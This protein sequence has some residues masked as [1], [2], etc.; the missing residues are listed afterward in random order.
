MFFERVGHFLDVVFMNNLLPGRWVMGLRFRINAE[1]FP[2]SRAHIF[3]VLGQKPIPDAI[4]TAIQP[5]ARQVLG[6]MYFFFCDFM[7]SKFFG[8]LFLPVKR[9]AQTFGDLVKC[10]GK[11]GQLVFGGQVDAMIE[12]AIGDRLHAFEDAFHTSRETSSCPEG[13]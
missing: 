8:K 12:I 13:H 4:R 3:E 7:N 6:A 10:I 11:V 9:F 5:E 2:E 1:D